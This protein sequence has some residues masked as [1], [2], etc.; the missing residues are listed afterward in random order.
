LGF[1]IAIDQ[2]SESGPMPETMQCYSLRGTPSLIVIDQKGNVR[3]NHFGH[4]DNL[5][6]G[7]LIGSLLAG[8]SLDL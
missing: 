6:V 8:Y 7:N 5:A 1:P 4:M 2:A 3:L